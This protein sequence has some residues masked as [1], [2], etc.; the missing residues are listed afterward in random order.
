MPQTTSERRINKVN[1]TVEKVEV[2]HTDGPSLGADAGPSFDAPVAS[3]P[4]VSEPDVET[5]NDAEHA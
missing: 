3:A 2:F 1:L 4:H 5:R